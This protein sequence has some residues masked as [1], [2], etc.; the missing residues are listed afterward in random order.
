M[1]LK[2]LSGGNFDKVCQN[3]I[4]QV[5]VFKFRTGSKSQI[6]ALSYTCG[7][8]FQPLVC[9][10]LD[11]LICLRFR[12]TRCMIEELPDFQIIAFS[13]PFHIKPRKIVRYGII[14]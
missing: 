2:T 8:F 3:I 9:S 12:N 5:T 7:V 6:N 4:I 10:N 14:D 11:L 13:L 1:I